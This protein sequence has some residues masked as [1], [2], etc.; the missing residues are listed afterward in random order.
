MKEV[1]RAGLSAVPGNEIAN[2]MLLT[3]RLRAEAL[4]LS[5][6]QIRPSFANLID[7][8]R[9]DD[10][11]INLSVVNHGSVVPIEAKRPR[12]CPRP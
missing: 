11:R 6:L 3:A 1:G 10:S 7:F 4:G 5:S 12:C 9:S 2:L 8:R